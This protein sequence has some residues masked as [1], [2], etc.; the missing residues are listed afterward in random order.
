MTFGLTWDV[1]DLPIG[2]SQKIVCPLIT[3][4]ADFEATH[5]ETSTTALCTDP[6]VSLPLPTGSDWIMMQRKVTRGSESFNKTWAEYR[7]GFGSATCNDNYWMGLDNV[8]HLVQ[9]SD[10]SLRV[11]VDRR[12]LLN[13]IQND[14]LY[15]RTV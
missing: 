13:T 7:H 10:L 2:G 6:A 8:Y 1:S 14:V 9:Q 3:D 4:V 15:I 5:Q 12:R 11:E